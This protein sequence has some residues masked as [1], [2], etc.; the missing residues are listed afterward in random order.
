MLKYIT[1]K[2]FSNNIV[3]VNGKRTPVGSFLGKL[4]SIHPTLLGGASIEGALKASKLNKE[5]VEEVIMGN[6]VS[7][8]LGQA[9][10]R[11]A[12]LKAGLLPSTVCTTVNKICASGMKAVHFG[13]QSIM[14]GNSQ[15]VVAGGMESLSLVP[16]YLYVR[17]PIPFGDPTLIDGIRLDG[18]TDSFN[19]LIMGSC[20]ERVNKEFKI[21]RKEQD[22]W[23]IRSYERAIAASKSG[24]LQKELVHIVSETGKK[25]VQET[26]S[27]DEECFKF[28]PDKIP[29]L[30]PVFEKDGSVTAANA[31]KNADGACA[32]VLM[33]EEHAKSRG[34]N[35][36]ARI[37]G[38]ADSEVDPVNFAIAPSSAIPKLLKKCKLNM[39]DI[40]Y[41]E[42]NEAFA[43]T[44]LANMKLL[45]LSGDKINVHGG[46]VALGHPFGMSGARIILS[47]INVLQ[48]KKGRLGIAAICN[49]GG[50]ASSIL[51][52]RLL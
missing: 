33:S 51:I 15:I 25:G 12:A 46:A 44:V 8:G 22:E 30:R 19:N 13:A 21:G 31:S 11:Q 18:L 32:M 23:A 41:F 35:P 38:F 52:E 26:V 49:G 42:I 16:H 6:V 4:S 1:K 5:E 7:S 43:G 34:L 48:E 17:K 14:T 9:P 39:S 45:N 47:L 2:T 3:I 10:A 36:I 27:Q 20:Q 28:M 50:G 29:N 37:L 24:V 40:D